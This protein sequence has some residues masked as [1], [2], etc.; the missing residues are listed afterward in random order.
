MEILARSS[1]A[2]P[3][4][5]LERVRRL[6][7]EVLG[8]ET[9]RGAG[10]RDAEVAVLLV[11]RRAMRTLNERYTGRRGSTDVLAF[12]MAGEAFSGPVLGDVY[13]C[14][15]EARAQ[16]RVSG[17]PQR[18]ALARL[19]IHGLLHLAG[20]DH[21]RGA[22]AARVMEARQEAYLN[23]WRRGRRLRPPGG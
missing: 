18:V 14:V 5:S 21:T 11:G 15:D 7:R 1:V 22:A 4:L 17:E 13:V 12:R 2:R 20:Y 16:A 3:G 10:G 6:A 8:A 9:I 23:A 19:V